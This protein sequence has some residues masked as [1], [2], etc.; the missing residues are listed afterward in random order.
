M[1]HNAVCLISASTIRVVH[2]ELYHHRKMFQ[3]LPRLT[4]PHMKCSHHPHRPM[5]THLRPH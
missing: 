2:R 5:R 3:R 1:P 4:D